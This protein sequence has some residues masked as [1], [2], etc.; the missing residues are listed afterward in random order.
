[1]ILVTG[2]L[3]LIL[4]FSF[5]PSKPVVSLKRLPVVFVHGYLGSER[6]LETMIQRFEQNG[7]GEKIAICEVDED[8]TLHWTR[9]NAPQGDELQLVQVVFKDASNSIEQ[10]AKWLDEVIK[11]VV[12][13][14]SQSDVYVIGHSM[15]GLASTAAVLYEQAPIAK[16]VTLGSPIEGLEYEQLMRHYPNSRN[17]QQS[18]GARDLQY[19]SLALQKLASEANKLT[20]PVFSGAGNIG[21]GTDQVVTIES[22]YGLQKFVPSI[23]LRTFSVG[24]SEL[25]ENNEVDRAV[26]EFL[27]EKGASS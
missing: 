15:G 27:D 3:G 7:W 6:S 11:Q 4:F 9:F 8:S 10:Q 24:H 13:D 2:I 5:Q 12:K 25:H 20:I 17:F 19:G 22:A 18:K 14:T 26:Y 21:D 1:M 16:L 23:Q